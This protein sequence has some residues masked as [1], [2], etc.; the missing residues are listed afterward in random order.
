MAY[1][2]K[3]QTGK[4]KVMNV[5]ITGGD[6]WIG[7]FCVKVLEEKGYKVF[8]WG[9]WYYSHHL[10]PEIFSEHEPKY[11]IHTAWDVNPPAY[12]ENPNNVNWFDRSIYLMRQFYQYGGKKVVVSGTCA[13]GTNTLYGRCK[14]SLREIMWEYCNIMG[15]GIGWATIFYPYGPYERPE[16]IIS[17]TIIHLLMDRKITIN[18]PEQMIDFIHVE[19]VA[20][21]MVA[22]ME[23]DQNGV[24]DVG[25]GEIRSLRRV[26]E[27]IGKELGRSD[28]LE[29]GTHPFPEYITADIRPLRSL[30]YTPKY[31]IH[32]GIKDTIEFW[33]QEIYATEVFQ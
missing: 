10:A 15:L 26:T 1:T 5:I 8:K 33:K 20:R 29:Y 22:I 4:G 14:K 19:D 31:N 25:Q 32:S 7:R 24:Y 21:A 2:E 11:L 6:G 12:W 18:H 13:E 28:L 23:S 17:S 9:K 16:K 27:I 3:S 30:G